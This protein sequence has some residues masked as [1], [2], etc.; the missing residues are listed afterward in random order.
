MARLRR[1]VTAT[2]LTALGAGLLVAMI[3]GVLV[4]G[5]GP[6]SVQPFG[7]LVLVLASLVLVA[8]GLSGGSRRRTGKGLAERRAEFGPRSRNASSDD[9]T[10]SNE[11]PWRRERE[12][13]RQ[14][15]RGD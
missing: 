14:S 4:A 11:D 7:F 3:A 15:G 12:R 5:L 9:V 6:K 10:V 8:G 13:R 1:F 2:R